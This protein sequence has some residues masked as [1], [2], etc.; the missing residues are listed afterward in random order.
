MTSR[1]PYAVKTKVENPDEGT[2]YHVE[3]QVDGHGNGRSLQQVE[4]TEKVHLTDDDSLLLARIFNNQQRQRDN[5]NKVYRMQKLQ[6]R[7]M[8]RNPQQ[9]GIMEQRIMDNRDMIDNTQRNMIDERTTDRTRHH[10]NMM[11]NSGRVEQLVGMHNRMTQKNFAD[12]RE[13]LDQRYSMA[14]QNRLMQEMKGRDRQSNIVMGGSLT[15]E[16]QRISP[17]T[18][19]RNIMGQRNMMVTRQP[20]RAQ[21]MNNQMGR[22]RIIDNRGVIDQRNSMGN[23]NMGLLEMNGQHGQRIMLNDNTVE[24]S[25]IFGRQMSLAGNLHGQMRA[26]D[27]TSSNKKNSY[28]KMIA[29]GRTKRSDDSYSYSVTALHPAVSRI[30]RIFNNDLSMERIRL[31]MNDGMTSYMVRPLTYIARL[32]DYLRTPAVMSQSP[33]Y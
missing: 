24:Q 11:Q 21:T 7:N 33:I 6:Q 25:P 5:R 13:M 27:N 1:E 8:N 14:D 9:N 4:Q 16:G 28:T 18:M 12:N 20:M 29:S 22:N 32:P 23:Q 30:S 31:G 19:S 17:M 10:Q 15:A 26:Q 3:V 2:K